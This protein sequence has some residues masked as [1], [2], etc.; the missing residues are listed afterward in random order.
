[1]TL[2]V[3]RNPEN[4]AP[5]DILKFKGLAEVVVKAKLQKR[6]AEL[7]ECA[8]KAFHDGM[9]AWVISATHLKA[10]RDELLYQH[11]GYADFKT[12]LEERF[13]GGRTTAFEYIKIAGAFPLPR[14]DESDMSDSKLPALY[15][16]DFVKLSALARLPAFH[17]D[18]LIKSG[19][20]I[21]PQG[22]HPRIFSVAE[23]KEMTR[24][25]VKTLVSSILGEG[26]SA[27]TG[28]TSSLDEGQI[29]DNLASHFENGFYSEQTLPI[30][31]EMIKLA[32]K[33]DPRARRSCAG[34]IEDVARVI[35]KY[36]SAIRA[37]K[38]FHILP[39]MEDDDGGKE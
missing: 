25:E 8:S 19:K 4:P 17:R 29:F 33:L 9:K 1:M 30:L 36:A 5:G 11:L 22:E 32:P 27:A 10:I 26:M 15:Q 18:T 21:V 24:D 14:G 7:L 16:L 20:L 38:E 13:D 2:P 35:V 6:C 31:E 12:F 34:Q 37:G 23:L 3:K 39:K 28:G